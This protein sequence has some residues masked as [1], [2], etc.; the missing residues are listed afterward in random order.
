MNRR[1]YYYLNTPDGAL[2]RCAVLIIGNDPFYLA[3]RFYG[4]DKVTACDACRGKLASFV[5]HVGGSAVYD[6]AAVRIVL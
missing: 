6:H 3:C 1:L 2:W 4:K 5:R